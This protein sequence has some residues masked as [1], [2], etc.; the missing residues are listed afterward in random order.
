MI[1]LDASVVVELLTNGALA[2]SIRSDLAGRNAMRT[3]LCW[4]AWLNR[5]NDSK[6]NCRRHRSPSGMF[7]NS[8]KSH[9]SRRGPVRILRPELP[10]AKPLGAA[11][12]V[13]SNQRLTVASAY[14]M[15]PEASRSGRCAPPA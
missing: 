6:R 1:V 9:C 10:N 7:L 8:E 11:N 4:A 13:T 5:L 2:D 12:A 3:R 15:T 14:G